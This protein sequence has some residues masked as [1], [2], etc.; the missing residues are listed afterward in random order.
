MEEV[1]TAVMKA[2]LVQIAEQL[3]QAKSRR[4]S[5]DTSPSA[6]SPATKSPFGSDRSPETIYESPVGAAGSS[7]SHS[8]KRSLVEACGEGELHDT[9]KQKLGLSIPIKY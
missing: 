6:S 4:A 7:E 2:D 5:S 1:T 3:A 9:K 8:R